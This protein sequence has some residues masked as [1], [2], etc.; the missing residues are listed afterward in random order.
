[1]HFPSLDESSHLL[2]H[3]TMVRA[4][5]AAADASSPPGSSRWVE[6]DVVVGEGHTA[7]AGDTV[8]VRQMGWRLPQVSGAGLPE[9]RGHTV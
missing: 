8:G 5:A 3:V 2:Q 4:L 9:A 6:Q 1:M 7:S